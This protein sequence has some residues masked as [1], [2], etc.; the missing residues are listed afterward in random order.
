M[1]GKRQHLSS[2][3][4]RAVIL[5]VRDY[6]Y[7][8]T[9]CTSNDVHISYISRH[10][11]NNNQEKSIEVY[12]FV[13]ANVKDIPVTFTVK[14]LINLMRRATGKGGQ[15]DR[16]SQT[17]IAYFNEWNMPTQSTIVSNKEVSIV[18]DNRAAVFT[19]ILQRG[20]AKIEPLSTVDDISN[21]TIGSIKCTL[22]RFTVSEILTN[23]FTIVEF[24]EKLGINLS[25]IKK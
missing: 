13:K 6:V 16:S 11:I 10:I 4:R 3:A 15:S 19:Q 22:P 17:A 7:R 25:S 2:M 5:A 9:S 12:N 1:K 20:K 23:K 18:N 24:L 8:L 21:T 14:S